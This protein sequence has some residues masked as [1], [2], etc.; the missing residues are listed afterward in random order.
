[1]CGIFAH[2]GCNCDQ[3]LQKKNYNKIKHRGP[4][5]TVIKK[6]NDKLL[7]I[8]HRLVINGLDHDSDQPLCIKNKWL[9][10]N[11]EI[12]N[13]RKLWQD[14]GFNYKTHSDCEIII[15]MYIKFGFENTLKQL[16]G[17]FACV[18]YDADIDKL[19][20]A[21]D[22]IGI[23]SLY[24]G[25][26]YDKKNIGFCSEGKALMSFDEVK[27]FP[28]GCWLENGIFH[29]YYEYI[30]HIKYELSESDICHRLKELLTK[31]VEKRM[32]SD[33]RVCTLLSGGLDS[34]LVTALVNK[35]YIDNDLGKLDTYSIGMEGSVDLYY[36]KKASKYIGTNHHEVIVTEGEFLNAIE[37]TIYQI[38]SYCVTSVR[39][40][41]G[42]YLVSLYI[43]NHGDHK[44]D[45][46]YKFDGNSNIVVFCGDL[47]DEI[48]A[49]YRGF[50]KADSVQNFYNENIKMLENVHYYDV[51]RSDKSISGAGLE[52]RVPFAD[53]TF[54]D[55][56][57]SI[58]PELKM[59]DNQKMEKYLLRKAFMPEEGQEGL[60]SQELL[61]RRKEAFS[62]GVSSHSRSWFEII[63]E[64][65]DSKIS[66]DEYEER[67]NKFTY[68]HPSSERSVQP[69]VEPYDKESLYYREIFERFY[70]GRGEMIPYYWRHPFSKELDPSARLLDVY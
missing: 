62:D 44:K 46:E 61:W 23:R 64:F 12:Y 38:E 43:R 53:K 22:P 28:P 48:F 7:M 31:A 66:D 68:M 50:Q 20:V 25:I 21:R 60:L 19:Y 56:V 42:N 33:R 49:S 18:L 3:I 63:K 35:Y 4:D 29:R 57:M 41:V 51:L 17:V 69:L 9:I 45:S 67:C 59:F 39:A 52:A 2:Y 36:A 10:C 26:D 47:S 40:S 8:F 70:P 14:N 58:D 11:G 34:T 37:K 24:Y 15:H 6:V 16:D 32:M 27:Q 1:M 13:Y 55:F 54:V 5:N 65:V 30:Y